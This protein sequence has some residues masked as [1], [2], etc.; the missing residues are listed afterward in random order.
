VGCLGCCRTGVVVALSVTALVGAT[1]APA[2]AAAGSLDATF[3]GDGIVKTDFGSDNEFAFAV[4]VQADGKIVSAGFT[5]TDSGHDFAL[6]RYKTGGKLDT[7]FGGDGKVTTGFFTC[8]LLLCIP[9]EDIATAVAIQDDGKIVVA[10]SSGSQFALA[11][12]NRNGTLD[13]TFSGDG[14]LLTSF[15]SSQA[16]ANGVA[17]QTGGK[18]VA[19]GTA[20]GPASNYDFAL[21][22]YKPNGALDTAFS[23]DGKQLT[24]FGP[25]RD[26]EAGAVVIQSDGKIVLAGQSFVHGDLTTRD[27]AI[28]RYKPGGGLDGSFS[29]DGKNRTDFGGTD[30]GASAL[31]GQAD[32]KLVAAGWA[33]SSTAAVRYTSVGSLDSS[34][35]GDGKLTT[36]FGSQSSWHAIAVQADGKIV[37]AG[38][39]G[40]NADSDFALARYKPGGGLDLTFSGDGKVTTDMG[41]TD[42]AAFGLAIQ[43]DGKLVATGASVPDFATARYL[44]A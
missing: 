11:R 12:Y 40:I 30:D 16:V 6:A 31:A 23:G 36:N 34:F 7:S 22:R 44:A 28:A 2:R 41:S 10:G 27:F 29:F 24:D 9:R 3:S 21:A 15:G 14:R 5:Q 39:V 18:I 33:G 38:S 17:I 43:A 32:G 20:V 13:T 42:E 26:D 19:G 37:A 8:V 1:A 25:S 4:A 35:S